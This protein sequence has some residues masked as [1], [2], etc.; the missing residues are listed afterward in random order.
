MFLLKDFTEL[1]ISSTTLQI[2]PPQSFPSFVDYNYTGSNS[3]ATLR[4]VNSDTDDLD[5]LDY[6][7]LLFNISCP[8]NS[9]YHALG[10]GWE[11]MPYTQSKD[12]GQRSELL[13]SKSKKYEAVKYLQEKL[14]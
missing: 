12:G 1:P 2:Q 5:G 8:I 3:N 9:L 10:S 4:L 6:L 7:I 11:I 14:D 13:I